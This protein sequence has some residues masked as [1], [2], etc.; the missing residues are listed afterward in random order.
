M[1][2]KENPYTS[3]LQNQVNNPSVTIAQRTLDRAKDILKLLNTPKKI[4]REHLEGYCFQ[5]IPDE[6]NGLRSLC[7]KIL[8]NYLPNCPS[9]WDSALHSYHQTYENYLKE[10]FLP[11]KKLT[12]QPPT[13]YEGDPL[14][15][16]QELPKSTKSS[17]KTVDFPKKDR[18]G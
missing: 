16:S 17:R 7:W 10:Y 13:K 11:H 1:E 8:L 2:A 14:N 4:N 5:G 9:K 15:L 18:I 3:H 6:F 12:L